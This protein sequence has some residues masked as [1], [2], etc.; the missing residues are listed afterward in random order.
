MV[1]VVPQVRP[2]DFPQAERPPPFSPE[3][4]A[5]LQ[6][7]GP[8]PPPPVRFYVEP[9]APRGSAAELSGDLPGHIQ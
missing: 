4:E 5:A 9:G 3:A 7:A 8:R 2:N 6:V 1:R